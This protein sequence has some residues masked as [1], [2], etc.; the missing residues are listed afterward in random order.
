MTGFFNRD[1][2]VP[3]WNGRERG[4]HLCDGPERIARPVDEQCR[5][6][7]PR[8]VLS[9]ELLRLTRRVQWIG[10][11]QQRIGDGGVLGSEECSLP[12]PV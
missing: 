7:Q 8:E 12:S 6:L 10:E 2:L 11:E 3:R 9:T 4:S 1:Q 5:R